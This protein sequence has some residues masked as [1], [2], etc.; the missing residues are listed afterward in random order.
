MSKYLIFLCWSLSYLK[1]SIILN[2]AIL[3]L[4]PLFQGNKE[5][6]LT[7]LEIKSFIKRDKM[8]AAPFQLKNN[9]N[10]NKKETI[11]KTGVLKAK[12]VDSKST[13][14]A[15]LKRVK[16][17]KRDGQGAAT[18]KR[19]TH[20]Q[21]FLG[22]QAVKDKKIIDVTVAKPLATVT[23]KPVPGMYKGKVVQSKIGAIWKTSATVGRAEPRTLTT[24]AEVQNATKV[25]STSV[26]DLPRHAKPAQTRAKPVLDKPAQLSRPT[27]TSRPPVGSLSA[28]PSTRTVH[29]KLTSTTCRNSNM[30]FTKKNAMET[31][32]PSIPGK[33]KFNRPSVSSTLSQ[34]RFTMETAEERRYCSFS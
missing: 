25:Q 7:A 20:S 26:A 24:K 33:D 28:R 30:V 16:T 34:Y 29:V 6:D 11:P 1:Y 3:S 18:E 23:S 2:L 32:K 19:Q 31:S 17:F 14:A 4:F 13:S 22:E 21:V 12:E 5:N 8:P 27:V 9:N 10:N 15:T